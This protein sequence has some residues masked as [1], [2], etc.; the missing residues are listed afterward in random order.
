[1]NR[2]KVYLAGPITD[3][4]WRSCII[5]E[6]QVSDKEEYRFL[7]QEADSCIITGAHSISCDHRCY[8]R[9]RHAATPNS[10]GYDCLGLNITNQD[11]WDACKSQI[12][13][14]D[15]VF[16][17]IDND[18]AHGTLAE[19]GFAVGVHKPVYILFKDAELEKTHWFVETMASRSY[20][21]A[22][23][24]G[25]GNSV[26]RALSCALEDYKIRHEGR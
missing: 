10:E 23:W 18:H 2:P 15:F 1:M 4:H 9:G 3:N 19:I 8:H 13:K 25:I 6:R 7:E 5:D 11:V 12:I 21:T 16:A 14:S 26:T 24:F 22:D 17:Y 20:T